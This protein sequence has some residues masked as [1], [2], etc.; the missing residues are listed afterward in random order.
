MPNPRR[1][2][3]VEA[4]HVAALIELGTET[5]LSPWGAHDYLSEIKDK[6][7]IMLRLE[8]DVNHTIGFIVG[9]LITAADGSGIDAEIYNIAVSPHHQREGNGQ[10]LFDAFFERCRQANVCRIWLEVRVSNEKAISFYTH[11]SFAIQHLRKGLYRSPPEDG[12][13]MS[14][15]L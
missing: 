6:N 8:T 10:L 3:P 11:N 5:G 4:A 14:R 12:Y 9:R 7:S 2:R 1:I 13:L 15:T